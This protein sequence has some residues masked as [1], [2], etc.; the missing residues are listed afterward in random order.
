M[1]AA[2]RA[3]IAFLVPVGCS[4]VSPA[5]QMRYGTTGQLRRAGFGP[6]CIAELGELRTA[7]EEYQRG[8]LSRQQ[9][10]QVVDAFA[11]RP[12]FELSWV[13]RIL[14]ATP[15][16]DGLSG[17]GHPLRPSRSP[18]AHEPRQ[19]PGRDHPAL[20]TGR[21]C[22]QGF[23]RAGALRGGEPGADLADVGVLQVVENL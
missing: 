1:T 9:A 17:G 11:D 12:W 5:R 21:F 18:Q 3:D 2:A 16:W 10:Q 14:P 20:T 4:T 19:R 15:D 13:P 6:A 7:Y 22:R 23:G 8:L